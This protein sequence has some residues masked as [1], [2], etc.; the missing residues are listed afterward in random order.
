M[1]SVEVLTQDFSRAFQQ[2]SDWRKGKASKTSTVTR[3]QIES[4]VRRINEIENARPTHSVDET[5]AAID[6]VMARGVEGWSN[7]EH[8]QNRAA[9]RKI[10]W[11]LFEFLDD[12]HRDIERAVIDPPFVSFAWR[13]KSAWRNLDMPGCTILEVNEAGLIVCYWI[14]PDPA[15]LMALE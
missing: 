5:I 9:E 7:N 4:V 3:E 10:E 8:R 11:V 15:P 1:P 13:I 2:H 12:Y 6:S 14:Y